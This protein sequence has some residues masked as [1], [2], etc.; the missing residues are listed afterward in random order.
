MIDH[1][2]GSVRQITNGLVRFA[3]F[4]HQIQFQLIAGSGGGT[5]RSRE[6]SEIQR[7]DLLQT[8]DLA[9]GLVVGEEPSL[10]QFRDSNQPR[11]DGKIGVARRVVNGQIKLAR[12]LELIQNV[13]AAPAA[14]ALYR[15]A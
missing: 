4:L 13:E 3:T 15:V 1:D 5:Q 12:L 7:R 14:L 9:E 10:Q 8:R 6:I 11:I 2:H